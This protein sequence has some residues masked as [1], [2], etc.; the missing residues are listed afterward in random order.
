MNK[1]DIVKII[2]DI[3]QY[4]NNIDHITIIGGEP[5]THPH[6]LEIC[7]TIKDSTDIKLEVST[8]GSNND[9]YMKVVTD[10]GIHM[11][12]YNNSNTMDKKYKNH[13]NLYLSPHEEKQ[14]IRDDCGLN[15]GIS[16]FKMNENIYYT[17]CAN[18]K[19]ICILLDRMDLFYTNIHDIMNVDVY[20][21]CL[22][23]ETCKHCQFLAKNRI[24]YCDNKKISNIF[25]DGIYKYQKIR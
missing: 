14:E 3:N 11:Y 22:T 18:Q 5:T 13:L 7:K 19:L 25:R 23:M 24:H 2:N 21:N 10:M 8:N 15:C 17:L 6:F 1:D 9:K 4:K 12:T 20:D 16:I